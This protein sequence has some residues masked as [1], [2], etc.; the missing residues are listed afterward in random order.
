[1]NWPVIGLS[2]MQPMVIPEKPHNKAK[3]EVRR[4][5]ASRFFIL[6]K[7]EYKP[8]GGAAAR[9]TFPYRRQRQIAVLHI[10]KGESLKYKCVLIDEMSDVWYNKNNN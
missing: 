2:K 3:N 7:K 8:P 9:R 4:F 6:K 10:E 1:M 5:V